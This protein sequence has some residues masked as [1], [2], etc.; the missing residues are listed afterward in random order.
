MAKKRRLQNAKE[1]NDPSP[2]TVHARTRELILKIYRASIDLDRLLTDYF[3]EVKQQTSSGM[4]TDERISLLFRLRKLGE[5]L[6]VL[7][8]D[9]PRHRPQILEIQN[10]C[11]Q[12]ILESTVSTPTVLGPQPVRNRRKYGL[13][14][15]FII[16][17]WEQVRSS[18]L[19]A[20]QSLRV[21]FNPWRIGL[22]ATLAATLVLMAKLIDPSVINQPSAPMVESADLKCPDAALADAGSQYSDKVSVGCGGQHPCEDASISPGALR[23][24]GQEDLRSKPRPEKTEDRPPPV[25]PTDASASV[26]AH[27]PDLAEF[28]LPDLARG[29]AISACPESVTIDVLTGSDTSVNQEQSKRKLIAS[30]IATAK[31]DQVVEIRPSCDESASSASTA[32]IRF[33]SKLKIQNAVIETKKMCPPGSSR[34]CYDLTS[35][36]ITCEFSFAINGFTAGYSCPIGKYFDPVN[37]EITYHESSL[38][39]PQWD[40]A[41]R[42]DYAI[43]KCRLLAGSVVQVSVCKRR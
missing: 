15:A 5:I 17:L 28:H 38:E 13:L 34:N 10:G 30:M 6:N 39:Q 31:I 2:P 23:D 43:D 18:L 9:S 33:V 11:T 32:P 14:V 3:P 26:N 4:T 21:M 27:P 37:F 22:M 35:R 7:L 29:P 42:G 12:Q 8:A 20:W 25:E 41:R 36:R 1:S 19:A 24:M 40:A 16:A